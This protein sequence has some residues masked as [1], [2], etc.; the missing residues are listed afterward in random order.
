MG[1][2]LGTNTL[3]SAQQPYNLPASGGVNHYNVQDRMFHLETEVVLRPSCDDVGM[4]LQAAFCA[5]R[6]RDLTQRRR[7][8]GP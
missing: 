3:L 1:K 4:A 2:G 7:Q 5:M 6:R 8:G